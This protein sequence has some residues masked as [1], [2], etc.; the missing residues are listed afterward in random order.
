MWPL[1]R[2]N[3]TRSDIKLSEETID[4]NETL[5]KHTHTHTQRLKPVVPPLCRLVTVDQI[6]GAKRK[7]L[8]DLWGKLYMC[9]CPVSDFSVCSVNFRH[10]RIHTKR[11]SHMKMQ[12]E[13]EE[14]DDL[15]TLEVLDEARESRFR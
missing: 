9:R 1:I 8:G 2:C 12:M 10:E 3:Q 4:C 6:T 7:N 14:V 15:A 5:L 13:P 11:G